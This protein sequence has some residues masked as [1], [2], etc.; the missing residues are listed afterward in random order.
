MAALIRIAI[1]AT[2]AFAN[3]T[4]GFGV[5]LGQISA[6]DLRAAGYDV[7]EVVLFFKSGLSLD[8]APSEKLEMVALT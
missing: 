2:V 8:F 4:C 7:I 1:I 3:F 5:A 6:E